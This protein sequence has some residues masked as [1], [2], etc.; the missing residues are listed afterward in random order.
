MNKLCVFNYHITNENSD[1]LEVYIDGGIVDAESQ[2][3]YKTWYNDETSVS[4]KSF[5]NEILSSGKK[6]IRITLNS[7]GGQIGDAMAMHDFIKQLENEG[8]EVETLG[9]GMI[10]SSATYPLSAAKNSKISP[11]SWY[12]IHNVSGYA[13]GDINEIEKSA[14]NLRKFNN[15]IRD[16]YVNLT[17]KS[18]EQIESWMNEEKWFT[19]KQAVENGFVKSLALEEKEEFKPINQKEWS[20]KNTHVL[21][22]YNSFSSP[23]PNNI[24]NKIDM[25]EL[26]QKIVNAFKG[27]NLVVTENT[28]KPENLTVENLTKALN[29]ATK[30][31]KLEPSEEQ[32]KH[33]VVNL[34]KDGLPENIKE[35]INLAIS[36]SVKER[37]NEYITSEELSKINKE[38]NDLKVDVINSLGEAKPPK[39][40]QEEEEKTYNHPGI[41][42]G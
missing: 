27:N 26:V 15:D 8:Y 25:N 32:I 16:F 13:Y 40:I 31:L 22:A 30:D 3:F 20:F 34:F 11:N 19:G 38:F 2:E 4:F 39:N 7:F 42:W 5:R 14:K 29:E 12:M 18:Q 23:K 17:G 21:N 9:M 24:N 41:K 6:N 35:V 1:R 36:D 37:M 10:C 28:P 33:S